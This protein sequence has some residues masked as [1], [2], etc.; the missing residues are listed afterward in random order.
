MPRLR[1]LAA[2]LLLAALG[3]GGRAAGTD[4][5]TKDGPVEAASGD[6]RSDADVDP[7]CQGLA[8]GMACDGLGPLNSRASCQGGRCLPG[9]LGDPSR[10]PCTT[11]WDLPKSC[12]APDERC[13]FVGF[14]EVGCRRGAEPCPVTGVDGGGGG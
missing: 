9:C 4:A 1:A 14:E 13:C 3:C 5:G 11:F 2:I 8:E 12:C 6:S 7:A 10:L